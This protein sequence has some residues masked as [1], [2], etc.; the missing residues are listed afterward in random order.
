MVD[1]TDI[2]SLRSFVVDKNNTDTTQSGEIAVEN[3]YSHSVLV[4]CG[5]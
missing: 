3:N 2:G 1:G 5:R 4:V